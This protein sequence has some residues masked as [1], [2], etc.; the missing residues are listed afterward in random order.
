MSE[1]TACGP[2]A[3]RQCFD[4]VVRLVR[5]RRRHHRRRRASWDAW[6]R[7]GNSFRDRVCAKYRSSGTWRA[8]PLRISVGT[9]RGPVWLL[10]CCCGLLSLQGDDAI[11]CVPPTLSRDALEPYP[12]WSTSAKRTIISLE[13]WVGK[14]SGVQVRVKTP[15]Q[16]KYP[17]CCGVAA[18]GF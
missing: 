11:V 12:W 10:R 14:D 13:G 7:P 18:V 8:A 17:S 4:G 16:C 6:G 2:A 9:P 1:T 5:R 15:R 3:S